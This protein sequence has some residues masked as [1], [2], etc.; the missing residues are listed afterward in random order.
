LDTPSLL[1]QTEHEYEKLRPI[2]NACG[3]SLPPR[4]FYWAVNLAFHT[5]ESQ[6]YEREHAHMIA[7]MPQKWDRLLQPLRERTASSIRWLDVGCGPGVLGNVVAGMLGARI[8][9]GVFLDPNSSML[10]LCESKA[11]SWPFASEFVRGTIADLD[12]D[13]KFDLITCNSV[14]HH[15]VE[16]KDFC[17]QI[18]NLLSSHGVFAHCYDPR[19]EGL[20]DR[21]L[22]R[23]TAAA[24]YAHAWRAVGYRISEAWRKVTRAPSAAKIVET[25][26]NGE[27]LA[28]GALRSPL[29]IRSI[30]AV[31]DFHVPRQPGSFGEGLSEEELRSYLSDLTLREY[32][33]YCYFGRDDVVTPFKQ[34]DNELFKRRDSHGA[35]FGASWMKT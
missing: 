17:R 7:A 12:G 10:Q 11:R 14:L 27:L 32:F 28:R 4:D 5:A 30:W 9:E 33:S 21:V 6:R 13:G 3:T 24:R 31:T 18:A 15:I 29:D 35:L 20:S 19:R 34:F 8:K 22:L 16:L 1:Q 25:E 23:R 2:M 26:T